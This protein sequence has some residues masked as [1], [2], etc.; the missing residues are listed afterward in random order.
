M[1]RKILDKAKPLLFGLG[2]TLFHLLMTMISNNSKYRALIQWDSR[3]Y[4]HIAEFGY[5]STIPPVAENPDLANVAFFP[6]YSMVASVIHGP[7]TSDAGIAILLAA[8]LAC[9]GTWAYLW[10]ILKQLKLSTHWIFAVSA[11]FMMQPVT[12][13]LLVGYS[14]STFVFGI[15]GF[16][17]WTHRWFE[18]RK[19]APLLLLLAGLHGAIMTSA[20]IV[21]VPLVIYPLLLLAIRY[22]DT[23]KIE[24]RRTIEAMAIG[25]LA[26]SGFAAFIA[27]C[28]FKFGMWNL[29]WETVR[30]GWNVEVNYRKL[31]TLRFLRDVAFVGSFPDLLGKTAMIVAI[32]ITWK[33]LRWSW[34]HQR[35][36][37][38][39]VTG[40]AALGFYLLI[41]TILG[42]TGSDFVGMLRYL[43]PVEVILLPVLATL[44][45]WHVD[46]GTWK[47]YAE[48]RW[49]VPVTGL[50]LL[51]FAIQIYFIGRFSASGWVS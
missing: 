14:E 8:Q 42:R 20:R 19:P 10:A 38:P 12:F 6:A 45:K 35:K 18:S 31:F 16:M 36:T 32:P 23:R 17:Y 37:Q 28:H 46:R 7:I 25:A 34:I 41:H 43:M 9:A 5:R 44:F 48:L 26:F 13:F 47:R 4:K 3:W 22:W 49:A 2:M 11:L 21:G 40:T 29:Y 50:I 39:L 15:V 30:I 27:Y 24:T 33:L 1:T 51:L